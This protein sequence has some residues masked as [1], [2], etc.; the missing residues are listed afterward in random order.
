MIL[1][2]SHTKFVFVDNENRITDCST[3]MAGEFLMNLT[4]S[5]VLSESLS[6]EFAEELDRKMAIKRCSDLQ[7]IRLRA[8]GRLK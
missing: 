7:T 6:K 5:S 1:P 2:G 3:T 4:Q 8:N